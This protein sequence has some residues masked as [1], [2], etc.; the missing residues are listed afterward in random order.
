MLAL[1]CLIL[2]IPLHVGLLVTHESL[3]TI[4]AG[5]PATPPH[6]VDAATGVILV[7]RRLQVTKFELLL[8]VIEVVIIILR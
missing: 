4:T 5:V 2:L 6:G 8:E 1:E 3:G 7:L